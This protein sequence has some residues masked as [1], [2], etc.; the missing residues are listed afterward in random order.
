MDLWFI[1]I[2][3]R[4]Q[5]NNPDI[6]IIGAGATGLMAARTLAKAGKQV[7]VLEA[8]DRC[9]GRIHTIQHGAFTTPTELGAEFV[10]GDLPVTLGLLKEADIP[11]H[12][13]GGEMWQYDKGKFSKEQEFIEGWDMLISKLG[14]LKKDVTIAVFLGDHFPGDK[15]AILRSSVIKFVSGYDTADPETASSFALRDEWKNEDNDAQHRIE[16]GYGALI[17][18][19]EQDIR[20][21]GG[22][23]C[24]NSVVRDVHWQIGKVEV[25]TVD[26]SVYQAGRLLIALPLGVLQA[27]RG[28]QGAISFHPAITGHVK[29]I[30]A[31]GFGAIIK[32]LLEFDAAFW[33]DR[34]LTGK[35]LEKMGFLF[36]EEEIPTWWTQSPQHSPL[37]TGWLGGPGAVA[38]KD[39]S[40]EQI[41]AMALQSLSNI[42]KI[43]GDKLKEKLATF[44][45]ANW[46]AEPFTRG[47]YAYD[48]IAASTSRKILNEPVDDTLFF[49]GEYLYEGAAM[50]TVEAALT[51]GR[52][53][54]KRMLEY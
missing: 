36:S 42:F 22:I 25:A 19:L 35:S 39:A 18:W 3:T 6:L 48:T 7:T 13:A 41:L 16:G 11:Y 31:M 17:R 50:G 47:S 20:K 34:E 32:V 30:G 1:Y 52:D 38:L 15:Y 53:V 8:R 54:A 28:E 29:A 51:S 9:G 33:E 49:A 24:L 12:P 26:G 27:R 10:H 14:E 21:A 23:I 4:Q 37:L 5:M 2:Y 43:A 46:T 45:V 44:H 40:D